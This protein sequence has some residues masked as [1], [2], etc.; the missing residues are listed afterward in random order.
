MSELAAYKWTKVYAVQTSMDNPV[1]VG[2][3]IVVND[4]NGG[5]KQ[6]VRSVTVMENRQGD[7]YKT[8][9]LKAVN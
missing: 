2:D 8:L 6:V 5:S 9:L 1:Q 7:P 4:R 3:E